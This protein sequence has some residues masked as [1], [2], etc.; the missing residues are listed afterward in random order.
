M[1]AGRDCLLLLMVG[2]FENW[3]NTNKEE[4]AI[5]ETVRFS[6]GTESGE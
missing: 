6:C 2:N 4:G 3:M 1:G 5:V